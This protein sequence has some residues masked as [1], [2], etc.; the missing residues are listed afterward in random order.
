MPD[1]ILMD[2][3]VIQL[4]AAREV[5]EDELGLDIPVAPW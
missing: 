4:N 1:L 3:G 2:G 5:I